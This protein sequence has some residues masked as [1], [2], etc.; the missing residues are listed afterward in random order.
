M[1]FESGARGIVELS[2]TR[3]LRNTAILRGERGE[4]EVGLWQN[5]LQLRL[6]G[7]PVELVGKGA[8]WHS[9][10]GPGQTT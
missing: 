5:S 10:G 1:T 2:R 6:S 8:S 7:S 3:N 4:L 9:T